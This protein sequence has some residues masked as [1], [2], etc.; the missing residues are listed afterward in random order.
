MSPGLLRLRRCPFRKRSRSNPLSQQ[1][2]LCVSIPMFRPT[3]P[4]R[5]RIVAAYRLDLLAPLSAHFP[6]HP[7]QD[8]GTAR[9]KQRYTVN[10]AIDPYHT[11]K[12]LPMTYDRTCTYTTVNN[13]RLI[14]KTVCVAKRL[15]ASLWSIVTGA[16]THGQTFRHLTVRASRSVKPFPWHLELRYNL[17]SCRISQLLLFAYFQLTN[18]HVHQCILSYPFLLLTQFICFARLQLSK[19]CSLVTYVIK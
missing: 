13:L 3:Y 19:I 15:V 1:S 4:P 8:G 17:E 18:I 7:Q 6:H 5:A 10:L 14:P 9:Q 11:G 12:F 16:R 2:Q